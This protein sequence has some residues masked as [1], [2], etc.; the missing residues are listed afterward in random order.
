MGCTMRLLPIF[1]I[2]ILV[3][4]VSISV[5]G[6]K[7]KGKVAKGKPSKTKPAKGK[8][9]TK[10]VKGKGKKKPAKKPKGEKPEGGEKPSTGKTK[11][12]PTKAQKELDSTYEEAKR[13]TERLTTL[14]K[15]LEDADKQI[16]ATRASSRHLL[17]DPEDLD[18]VIIVDATLGGY[19]TKCG[20]QV[21][22]SW[23]SNVN[24][25]HKGVAT[26]ATAEATVPFT[27]SSGTY[28]HP[29][30]SKDAW[31]NICA[32]ARFRNTGNSNDVTI[33]K[34]NSVIAAFGNADQRDWRSTGTC[35]I[36]LMTAGQTIQVKHE[37]GSSSD[38][39]EETGWYYTRLTIHTIANKA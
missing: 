15:E 4:I 13:L 29:T 16:N 32:F 33:R 19:Q 22:T 7:G 17:V 26:A 14:E 31:M 18:Q 36:E 37:S 35:V 30:G 2:C 5:E 39:I 28:T 6:K 11:P 23:T 27:T 34:S 25:W 9:K 10:P 8:G 21:I 24:E 20:A 1:L 38:C 12:K 3:L